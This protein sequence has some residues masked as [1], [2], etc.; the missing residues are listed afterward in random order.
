MRAWWLYWG[1]TAAPFNDWYAR[2][3]EK[4]QKQGIDIDVLCRSE[5]VNWVVKSYTDLATDK[6]NVLRGWTLSGVRGWTLSGVRGWTLSGVRGWT[7]SGVRGWTLSGVSD[8]A[9]RLCDY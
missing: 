4:Q 8:A 5:D 7:L 2:D 3:I 9:K 1:Q 6:N